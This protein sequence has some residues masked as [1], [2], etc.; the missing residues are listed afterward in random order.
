M[1]DGANIANRN[2][3]AVALVTEKFWTQGI[4]VA[5]AAGM[6]DVPRVQLPHPVAGTGRTSMRAVAQRV[7]PDIVAA[8]RGTVA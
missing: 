6:P 2:I 4:H 8:L 7:A 3:A 1:R 5:R